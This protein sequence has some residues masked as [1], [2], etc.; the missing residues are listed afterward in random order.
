MIT[1]AD[2]YL[3][4]GE[5]ED[6]GI[7]TSEQ[8]RKLSRTNGVDIGVIKFINDNRGLEL[9]KFY[10]KIRRSYNSGKSKLYINIMK[11]TDDLNDVLTTLSALLTQIILFSKGTKDEELFFKHARCDEIS[12]AIAKYFATYD[13]IPCIQ[14]IKLIKA[15]IKAL[16][17]V[18]R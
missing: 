11:E 9:T 1:R 4:L 3:L 2:L 13:L 7:D 5:I 16:E 10:E 12:R 17:Y 18:S 14:L 15:D 8:I 6:N